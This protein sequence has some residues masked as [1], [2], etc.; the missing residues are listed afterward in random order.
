MTER[1]ILPDYSALE[2]PVDIWSQPF[3]EAGASGRLLFPSCQDCGT[4]RWPA[5]PFCPECRGQEVDWGPAGQGRIYSYT[6]LPDRAEPLKFRIAALA[7]F[8]EAP[9]VRLVLTLAGA[10]KEQVVI[11]AKVDVR[12]VPAANFSVPVFMLSPTE[13]NEPL[14]PQ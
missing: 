9:G 8:D 3:W 2:I 12:W 4:F 13:E 11:G 10:A 1:S 14:S 7:E 6:I 5:G